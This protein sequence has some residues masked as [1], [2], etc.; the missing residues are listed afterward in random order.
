MPVNRGTGAGG[1]NTNA[2]G[3]AFEGKTA[4][5]QR[6]EAAG[7][8][9]RGIPGSHGKY[10]YYLQKGDTVF[11]MKGGLKL[12]MRKTFGA[13]IFREPDEAY[14]EKRGDR[15]VLKILEKKNQTMEGS[16][17]TK[18][19]AGPGF[20]EEYRM[21]LGEKFDVEYAF[22]VSNFLKEK[23]VSEEPKWRCLRE[24]NKKYGIQVLYGDDADYFEKLDAWI[25]A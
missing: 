20:L 16:V 22:C 8:V 21:S 19:L 18:L 2:L 14:I 24:I 10:A 5:E 3:L 11:M 4:N 15:L 12:Y 1:G 13:D 7:F 9:R 6:L 25:Q 17:D 23:V